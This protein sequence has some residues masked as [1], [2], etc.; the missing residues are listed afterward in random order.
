[1][2]FIVYEMWYC[3]YKLYHTSNDLKVVAE[4]EEPLRIQDAY[5]GGRTNAINLKEEFSDEIKGGYVDFCSLYPYVLKYENYP[6]GHPVH[7]NGNFT[8]QFHLLHALQNL[9]LY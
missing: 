3:D 2:G 8:S 1:M 5:F 9:V 4:E 6:V 7:I